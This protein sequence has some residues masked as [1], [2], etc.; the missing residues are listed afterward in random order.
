MKSSDKHQSLEATVE[1]LIKYDKNREKGKL[2]MIEEDSESLWNFTRVEKR[3]KLDKKNWEK[4]SKKLD[5]SEELRQKRNK[6]LAEWKKK[7]AKKLREYHAEYM[8][9]KRKNE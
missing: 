6:Y 5:E 4:Y 7:N 8:R 9:E 3:K 2:L 1:A